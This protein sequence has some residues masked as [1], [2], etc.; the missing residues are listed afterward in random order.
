[1]VEYT[2]Q[3]FLLLGIASV[4]RLLFLNNKDT[5]QWVTRYLL[6]KMQQEKKIDH[7]NY[8]NVYESYNVVL[9]GGSIIEEWLRVSFGS[10]IAN[11][12]MVGKHASVTIGSVV[13]KDV[14]EV[15]RVSGNFAIEHNKLI[16]HIKE[17]SK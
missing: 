2:I 9:G 8:N 1:M 12:C 5:D 4:L 3:L 17:I 7:K 16:Q 14:P 13:T 11:Y 6:K 10:N 15:M